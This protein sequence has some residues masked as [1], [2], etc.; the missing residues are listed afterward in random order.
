MQLTDVSKGWVLQFLAGFLHIGFYLFLKLAKEEGGAPLL[1][2][3]MGHLAALGV[4]YIFAPAPPIP[5][6]ISNKA[7]IRNAALIIHSC[8]AMCYSFSMAIAVTAI[9]A[10]DSVAIYATCNPVTLLMAVVFHRD[11]MTSRLL[12]ATFL[13][14]IGI[15]LITR[16]A[17]MGTFVDTSRPHYVNDTVGYWFVAIGTFTSAMANFTIENIDP[18]I[19]LET[20]THVSY[21]F[22]V[23]FGVF[24]SYLLEP[25]FSTSV[26]NLELVYI[27][28]FGVSISAGHL[29]WQSAS[30]Q[31]PPLHQ[32]LIF[33]I[34]NFWAFIVGAVLFHERVPFTSILGAILISCANIITAKE[35]TESKSQDELISLQNTTTST[36]KQQRRKPYKRKKKYTDYQ[37]V[38]ELDL[39]NLSEP[40]DFDNP[41][42]IGR[43]ITFGKNNPYLEEIERSLRR[44]GNILNRSF[45][46]VGTYYGKPAEGEDPELGSIN[47]STY[48]REEMQEMQIEGKQDDV[49]Y[50]RQFLRGSLPM[51]T[52]IP[53]IDVPGIG[54]IK[55]SL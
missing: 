42:I 29:L 31:I 51:S 24:L 52:T 34:D 11:R 47:A 36:I 30:T 45:G 14:I 35:G 33:S 26:S 6:T 23:V 41:K 28:A 27:M 9:G 17:F 55:F 43:P 53:T 12:I 16:P 1:V 3:G 46:P 32:R 20:V 15:L 19:P 8:T 37:V 40:E 22:R 13:C 54:V 38:Q 44:E 39:G 21:G 50:L 48:Q 18:A 4:L 10:G 7:P 5:P 2:S 25:E 49:G